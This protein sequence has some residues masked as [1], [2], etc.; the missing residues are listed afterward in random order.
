MKSALIIQ[1]WYKRYKS[2]NEM[3]RLTAW[4]I[5][6]S[7]EYCGE[8][9]QLKLYD[10][11]LALIRNRFLINNNNLSRHVSHNER[12]SMLTHSKTGLITKHEDKDFVSDESN[13]KV[14]DKIFQTANIAGIKKTDSKK[15]FY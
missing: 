15:I 6:Q 13:T 10:F 14:V 9:N 5:Y 11:F 7:I 3:R 1:R 4:K 2:R 12:E 8:Q